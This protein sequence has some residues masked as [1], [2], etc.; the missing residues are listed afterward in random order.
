MLLKIVTM[1]IYCLPLFTHLLTS[2]IPTP[3]RVLF[4]M[5]H[6]MTSLATN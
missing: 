6:D 5:T 1:Q 4:T 2:D 3:L